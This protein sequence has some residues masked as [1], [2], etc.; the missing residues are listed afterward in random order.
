MKNCEVR[1][2][3][4]DD[5]DEPSETALLFVAYVWIVLDSETSSN[6]LRGNRYPVSSASTLQMHSTVESQPLG[7]P[8]VTLQDPIRLLDLT[9]SR[10]ASHMYHTLSFDRHLSIALSQRSPIGGSPVS[11]VIHFWHLSSLPDA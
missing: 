10:I 1:P 2:I 9:T 7:E 6:A 11:T 4:L 5:F 8:T 3:L